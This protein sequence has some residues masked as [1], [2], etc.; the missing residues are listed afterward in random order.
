M[1]TKLASATLGSEP[2]HSLCDTLLAEG[3]CVV[4]N[5]M[6]V[7]DVGL[8]AADLAP[9][10]EAT[11][12]CEGGFWCSHQAVRESAQAIP[13]CAGVHPAPADH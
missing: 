2:H 5:L 9:H 11:P 10:F 13:T 8:L 4:P 1:A 6:P 3:F 7:R 12:F